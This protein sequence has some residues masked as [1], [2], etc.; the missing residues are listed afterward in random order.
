ME[1]LNELLQNEY[2]AMSGIEISWND[3]MESALQIVEGKMTKEE[4]L[5]VESKITAGFTAIEKI[6][7]E[8]GF[9]RGI[10]VAKGIKQLVGERG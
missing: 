2:A 6:A 4:F 3:E 5:E 9:L 8:Q 10:T 7:F 1:Q